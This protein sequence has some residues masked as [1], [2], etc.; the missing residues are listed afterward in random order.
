MEAARVDAISIHKIYN[1][2]RAYQYVRWFISALREGRLMCASA[3]EWAF[4]DW[5][6]AV[7]M[8]PVFFDET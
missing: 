3:A 1:I 5:E 4:A 7:R 6:D 2:R 8:F